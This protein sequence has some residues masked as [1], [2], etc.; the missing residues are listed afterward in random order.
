M[1]KN[2]INIFT[3]ETKKRKARKILNRQIQTGIRTTET[4]TNKAK[5]KTYS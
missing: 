4:D 2:V 3:N 1:Y 5:T